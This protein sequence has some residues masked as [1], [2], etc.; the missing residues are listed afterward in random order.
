M[1]STK[2]CYFISQSDK[3][4][5]VLKVRIPITKK[6]AI[7][8]LKKKLHIPKIYFIISCNEM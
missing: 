8:I 1:R 4:P 5:E 7:F 6:Q 3:H 2:W